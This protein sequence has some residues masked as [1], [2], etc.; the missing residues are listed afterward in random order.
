MV[1]PFILTHTKSIHPKN[2]TSIKSPHQSPQVQWE[3][4]QDTKKIKELQFF[5]KVNMN[6]EYVCSRLHIKVHIVRK[7]STRTT[8]PFSKRWTLPYTNCNQER[9]MYRWYLPH[10]I[11]TFISH[12]IELWVL[13]QSRKKNPIRM[14]TQRRWAHSCRFRVETYNVDTPSAQYK[15]IL[16]IDVNGIPSRLLLGP[17][18]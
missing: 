9:W 10:I 16:F 6:Q 15:E 13:S 18:N 4:I 11:Y 14:L 1:K 8:F 5:S 3:T 7:E 12:S 2:T 17:T